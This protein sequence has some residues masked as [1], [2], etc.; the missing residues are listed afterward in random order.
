MDLLTVV[1]HELGHVLGLADGC[2]CGSYSTLMQ[3]T[4]PIGVRRT[5]PIAPLP[6]T[7][8]S[9]PLITAGR[10]GHSTKATRHDAKRHRR[11]TTRRRD[12]HR[13]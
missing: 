9:R 1:L 13:R 3:A 11:R 12:R 7:L 10:E 5:L 4:L 2:S 8:R 6:A